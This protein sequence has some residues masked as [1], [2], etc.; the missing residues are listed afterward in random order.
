MYTH[1]YREKA[2]KYV[3]MY[4]YTFFLCMMIEK[5][6]QSHVVVIFHGYWSVIHTYPIIHNSRAAGTREQKHGG[7]EVRQKSF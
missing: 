7:T 6:E 4:I 3:H 2:G 5:C 1:K